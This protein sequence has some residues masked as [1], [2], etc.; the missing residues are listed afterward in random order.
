VNTKRLIELA[1]QVA[2]TSDYRIRVGAVLC[3]GNG[4]PQSSG[5]N[6]RKTHPLLKK[7]GYSE[8]SGIHAEMRACLRVREQDRVYGTLYVARLLR[9]G[10]RALAK[11]CPQCAHFLAEAGVKRVYYTEGASGVGEMRLM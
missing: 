3:C 9:S 1:A 10:E 8:Q 5:C 2:E 11:P 4:W 6:K 7:Y